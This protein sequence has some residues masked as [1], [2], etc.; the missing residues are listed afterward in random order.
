VAATL[1]HAAPPC[2]DERREALPR[3]PWRSLRV[4]FGMLLGEEDFT[5]IGAYH[6]GKGWLHNGWFHRHGVVWGF[7]VELALDNDEVRVLPGLALDALGRELHL[8]QTACLEA[9][10]WFDEHAEDPGFEV[11]DVPGGV[12]FTAHVI[13][14]FRPCLDRAV[15]A[16]AEPC[17]GD[18]RSV[19][20]SRVVE[21]VELLM[22]PGAAPPR[23]EPPLPYHRL[24]LLFGL[25]PAHVDEDG[26]PLPP[27]QTV[28]D[29][30][31]AI[32]AEAAEDQPTAW[33][34][35]FRRFAALDVVDLSP[36]AAADGESLTLV[37]GAEPGDLV[38]A[39]ITELTLLGSTGAWDL[40]SGD[41]DVTVRHAHVATAT[42]QELLCGSI[43]AGA[44]ALGGPGAEPAA[45]AAAPAPRARRARK[46]NASARKSK[47]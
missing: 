17:A 27:D 14:R 21:T 37:P 19:A 1:E 33:L 38:L 3:D 8:D 35:A 47:R 20:Y 43:L 31:D 7:G 44:A 24:R 25:E 29:A 39:E 36:A 34:D 23:T 32:L 6:R 13:A 9:G 5:T 15:P 2:L 22:R 30:R 16:M 45:A 4:R 46:K 42:I 28:L 12:R 10:A 40:D 18:E 26:D 11:E 41:V